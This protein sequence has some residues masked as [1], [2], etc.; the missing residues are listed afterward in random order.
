MI[1]TASAVLVG[2]LVSFVVPL[3]MYQRCIADYIMIGFS[4][5]FLWKLII[6]EEEK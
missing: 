1:L 6:T 5:W 2:Y 4:G 3:N